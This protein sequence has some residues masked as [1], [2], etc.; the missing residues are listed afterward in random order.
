MVIEGDARVRQVPHDV[1]EFPARRHR[2]IIAPSVVNPRPRC[3][4][5]DPAAR[6]TAPVVVDGGG[7]GLSSSFPPPREHVPAQVRVEYAPAQSRVIRP[8]VP[9]EWGGTIVIVAAA[10]AVAV[11]A[12]PVS[13]DLEEG[14]EFGYVIVPDDVDA[15]L[16]TTRPPVVVVVVAAAGLAIVVVAIIPFPPGAVSHI[17]QDKGQ[18]DVLRPGRAALR[19]RADEDVRRP[20]GEGLAFLDSRARGYGEQGHGGE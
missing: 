19:V 15:A 2:G 12:L 16:V 3:E 6:P 1:Y 17:R 20:E 9:G 5:L 13:V 7:G 11:A 10:A 8:H 18:D 4:T 14:R